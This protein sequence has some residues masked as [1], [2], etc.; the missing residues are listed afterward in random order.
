MEC[1]FSFLVK[2]NEHLL[3]LGFVNGIIFTG[4][5]T[6]YC[7]GDGLAPFLLSPCRTVEEA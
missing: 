3:V 4:F 5:G 1:H 6:E 7:H 2:E